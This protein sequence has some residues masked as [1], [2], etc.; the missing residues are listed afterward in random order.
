MHGRCV[1]V[2][3]DQWVFAPA[4]CVRLCQVPRSTHETRGKQGRREKKREKERRRTKEA[5]AMHLAPAAIPLTEFPRSS[6]LVGSRVWRKRKKGREHTSR[7]NC[8]LSKIVV[9]IRTRHRVED[10]EPRP[11][12]LALLDDRLLQRRSV[13]VFRR[14]RCGRKINSGKNMRIIAKF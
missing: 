5:L 8:T 4:V 2:P 3:A 6:F 10:A 9:G 7:I 13:D 12:G 14:K 11:V 1:R